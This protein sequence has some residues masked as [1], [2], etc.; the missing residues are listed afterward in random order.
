MCGFAGT[1]AATPAV[2]DGFVARLLHRGP[3][4][5]GVWLDEHVGLAHTRL[6]IIDLSPGG[7]QPM[8]SACGRW[9]IAYNGEIY[10]YRELRRGLE[11]RGVRLRSA[12]DTEV[13]LMLLA[14]DGVEALSG[15][16]GM[17]AFAFWDREKR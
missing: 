13:L 9:T 14:R 5:T 6:A 8:T 11:S 16:V 3:D 12:S 4:D 10:N 17:F 15:V 7:H 2:L 1:T